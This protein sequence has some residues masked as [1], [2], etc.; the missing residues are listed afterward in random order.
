MA[1]KPSDFDRHPITYD[2][3]RLLGRLRG[4]CRNVTDGDTF[5]FF[6]DLGLLHYAYV[7]I[8]LHA[9]DTYEIFN[10]ADAAELELGLK[11]RARVKELIYEQP[12]LLTTY[13]DQLTFGRYV[14]D[15]WYY[16]SMTATWVSLAT[17]LDNEGLLKQP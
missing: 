12:V 2:A 3:A 10:P 7:T 13:K 5:D 14:A 17:T 11:A 9:A 1:R 4:V 8:R 15:T 6:V 16:D